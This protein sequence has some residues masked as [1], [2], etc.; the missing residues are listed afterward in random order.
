MDL[1]TT[2]ESSEVTVSGGEGDRSS[3]QGRQRCLCPHSSSGERPGLTERTK[4]FRSDT[5]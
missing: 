5:W 2:P 1:E 4:E 3:V